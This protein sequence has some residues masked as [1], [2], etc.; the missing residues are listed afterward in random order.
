MKTE[1]IKHALLAVLL[2]TTFASAAQAQIAL[3]DTGR[4]IT[5]HTAI[6]SGQP[7][8]QYN[9][10]DFDS[11]AADG[12]FSNS[13]TEGKSLEYVQVLATISQNT[14]LTIASNHVQFGGT[15]HVNTSVAEEIDNNGAGGSDTRYETTA[16]L[17]IEVSEPVNYTLTAT[18]SNN[19]QLGSSGLIWYSTLTLT[20]DN[21]PTV[22]IGNASGGGS[23]PNSVSI[24]GTLAPGQHTL[25]VSAGEI[26]GVTNGSENHSTDRGVN[27]LFEVSAIIPPV[28]LRIVSAALSGTNFVASGSGGVTNGT[29][30]VLS[31]TNVALPLTNWSKLMTNGFDGTGNF[32]FTNVVSP[33]VPQRFYILSL[34]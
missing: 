21:F 11:T 2:A 33:T 4:E 5:A 3:H 6:Y 14:S 32:T 7:A 18:A 24:S 15:L 16:K 10:D 20:G 34:P 13:F 8:T 12:V 17:S 22:F 28:P 9:A 30:Y 29:Y 1:A 23:G 27:F 26:W 25:D 19:V 31:S